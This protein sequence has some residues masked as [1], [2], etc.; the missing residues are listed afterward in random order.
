[1][2]KERYHVILFVLYNNFLNYNIYAHK[3]SIWHVEQDDCEEYS[4]W[5]L[6]SMQLLH[7][8]DFGSRSHKSH[9]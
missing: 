2:Q 7:T 6:L 5:N 8:A 4:Y 1:M 3:G 9:C